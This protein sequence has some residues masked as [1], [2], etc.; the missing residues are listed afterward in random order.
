MYSYEKILVLAVWRPIATL[1][2]KWFQH[3]K[4]GFLPLLDGPPSFLGS[5]T[6][7]LTLAATMLAPASLLLCLTRWLE[8]RGFPVLNTPQPVFTSLYP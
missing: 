1:F 7:N 3:N 8:C 4:C 6:S 5:T 2:D